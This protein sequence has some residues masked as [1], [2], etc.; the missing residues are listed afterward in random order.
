MLKNR[1]F[2]IPLSFAL[3]LFLGILSYV[4]LMQ[5]K[6][7]TS[8][9]TKLGGD[10]TIATSQGEFNLKDY[11]GKIVVLYFGY[12]SCPDV[13]PTAL[14]MVG[15]GLKN[16]PTSIT[17]QVQPV[18]ISVD[19]E[20]DT[21]ENLKIYGEYF[22]PRLIAGTADTATIDAIVKQYG[23]YYK[24]TKQ[25][26]SVLNYMVD[27]TSRIYIINKEGEFSNT[28]THSSIQ[29][30]LEPALKALIEN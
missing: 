25:E 19:P 14:A 12:A 1:P 9:S 23:A 7:V 20:R 13:C 2:L 28:I 17:D 5:N 4:L 6:P 18:F 29:Q 24:I 10:F 30:D 15:N 27:H 26:N 21:L 22:H 8:N 11:R 3:A 16:M